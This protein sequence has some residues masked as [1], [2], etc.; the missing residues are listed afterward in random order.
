MDEHSGTPDSKGRPR[1]RPRRASLLWLAGLLLV[2]YS[3]AIAATGGVDVSFGGMRIRSR[4]WQRPAFLGVALLAGVAMADRRRAVS[5]A[6]RI[7]AAAG[8]NL[9]AA[10]L[11]LSP[12]AIAVVAT[13]WTLA[14]GVAFSTNI[15]GGADSSGYLNQARLFARGRVLEE[16]R[17]SLPGDWPAKGP[18]LAPLGY[19]PAPD[20]ERLAPTYP[21][22]YP[23]VM[24]PGF[25][26]DER[27]AHAVVPLCGALAVWLTFALGRRLR[28]PGTGAAAA[29]LVAVSPT[30]LYQLVQPMSDVPVT[31]AW[32][33]ALYC[34]SGSTT[35]AATCAGLAAGVAS[36]IRPN[37]LPLAVL[38]W[39]ACAMSNLSRGFWRRALTAAIATA[40]AVLT[41]GVIQA[42]RFGS[43][44]ASGYGRMRDLFAWENVIP[45]LDRYPRWIFETH[46]P[47]VALFLVAP[48]WIARRPPEMRRQLVI[49]WTFAMSVVLAYLPYTYFKSWEWTYTRFLLPALPLMWLLSLTPIAQALR[50]RS[51]AAAALITVPALVVLMLFSIVTARDRY[52]FGLRDGERKYVDAAE[53]VRR[54]LPLRT[55]VICLQHSG[56]VWFYTARP[57]LRWDQIEPRRLDGAL[58]WW[59][60][61]GYEPVIV[62]DSEEYENLKRRF[63]GAGQRAVGRARP[64]ARFGDATVYRFD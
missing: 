47:L 16:V 21:P 30:F 7:S 26:I 8:V 37:L 2:L 55:V 38:V 45:N 24:T 18:T 51:P 20:G 10:W 53:Y 32:L 40:P 61:E 50:R 22:G 5:L 1:A 9:G 58:A 44:W 29:L 46:T 56:S 15:A 33:L 25:L 60:S 6:S 14:V 64:V 11:G 3:G 63:S 57:I 49:V 52:V 12:R 13:V 43:P 34:A 23:L 48:L 42:I 19:R 27:A 54:V 17:V 59:S 28:E 41:L 39:T 62:A 4:T 31:A 36:A 35:V